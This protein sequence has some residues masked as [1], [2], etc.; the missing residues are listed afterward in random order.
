MGKCPA[1]SVDASR[2]SALWS[3]NTSHRTFG[4]GH[5]I[6]NGGRRPFD[7]RSST[8]R[9][10]GSSGLVFDHIVETPPHVK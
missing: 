4:Y 10:E 1:P 6:T 2:P 9:G 5:S 3:P 8:G 7:N